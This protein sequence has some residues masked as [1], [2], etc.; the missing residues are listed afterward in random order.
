MIA[1]FQGGPL[2][3]SLHSVPRAAEEVEI[4]DTVYRRV[5][6]AARGV[7]PVYEAVEPPVERPVEPES[8]A[9]LQ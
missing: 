1:W 7:H 5:P 8:E 9:E 6:E 2:D 3:R 4:A